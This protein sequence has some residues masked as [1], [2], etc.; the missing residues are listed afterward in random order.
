MGE[1]KDTF[2]KFDAINSLCCRV[3][4]DGKTETYHAEVLD[5]DIEATMH[6]LIMNEAY[7]LRARGGM[8]SMTIEFIPEVAPEKTG[9]E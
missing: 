2:I 9:R 1:T 4:K 8:P 3:R 6:L 7:D 5:G